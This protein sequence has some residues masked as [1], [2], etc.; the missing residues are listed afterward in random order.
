[1][2]KAFAGIQ[3]LLLAFVESA[4]HQQHLWESAFCQQHLQGVRLLAITI[5]D[6]HLPPTLLGVPMLWGET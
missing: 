3:L 6:V 2:P 4:F 1:M 5:M